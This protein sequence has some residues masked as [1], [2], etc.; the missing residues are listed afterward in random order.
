MDFVVLLMEIIYT[1]YVPGQKILAKIP[2]RYTDGV[3]L[4]GNVIITLGGKKKDGKR[5]FEFCFSMEVKSL[6]Y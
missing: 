2:E 6:G 3:L 1:K 5:D 4:V